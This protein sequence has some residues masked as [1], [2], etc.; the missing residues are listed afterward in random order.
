MPAHEVHG[1]QENKNEGNDLPRR[2][3]DGNGMGRNNVGEA[4]TTARAKEARERREDAGG[5][6]CSVPQ[7]REGRGIWIR[8]RR[9]A[10]A[11]FRGREEDG[12]SKIGGERVEPTV[13]ADKADI[14]RKKREGGKGHITSGSGAERAVSCK[15]ACWGLQTRGEGSRESPTVADIVS[16]PQGKWE[17]E[18]R[19][20]Q[21]LA[22]EYLSRL[23]TLSFN[24]EVDKRSNVDGRR[25]IRPNVSTP[26][27]AISSPKIQES[28]FV[29]KTSV[30][31]LNSS[32]INN[33]GR[34]FEIGVVS[35]LCLRLHTLPVKSFYL[36]PGSE[37]SSPEY[38]NTI[39]RRIKQRESSKNNH[40]S[41]LGCVAVLNRRAVW[42][43]RHHNIT[44]LPSSHSESANLPHVS[45]FQAP[46][47]ASKNADD[48]PKRLVRLRSY[49]SAPSSSCQATD[50]VAACRD[51]IDI[52]TGRTCS[53]SIL[54]QLLLVP[55]FRRASPT[56]QPCLMNSLSLSVGDSGGGNGD[57]GGWNSAPKGELGAAQNDAMVCRVALVVSRLFRVVPNSDS[58]A[59]GMLSD[60]AGPMSEGGASP[61][62]IST[63]TSA[64]HDLPLPS[65]RHLRSF[66]PSCGIHISCGRVDL[67][68]IP[69]APPLLFSLSR[70]SSSTFCLSLT[71]SLTQTHIRGSTTRTQPRLVSTTLQPPLPRPAIHRRL[72]AERA[73]LRR[74]FRYG[75]AIP[76]LE[77]RRGRG[78][79]MCAPRV[80]WSDCDASDPERGGR[81]TGSVF[82]GRFERGETCEG[83]VL[84]ARSVRDDGGRR[85]LQRCLRRVGASRPVSSVVRLPLIS[86]VADILTRVLLA[87]AVRALDVADSGPACRGVECCSLA[88]PSIDLVAYTGDSLS[89][90]LASDV[91][92]PCWISSY[93]YTDTTEGFGRWRESDIGVAGIAHWKYSDVMTPR[94]SGEVELSASLPPNPRAAYVDRIPRLPCCTRPRPPP[95]ALNLCP[96]CV[97]DAVPLAGISSRRLDVKISLYT[98][99][100]CHSLLCTAYASFSRISAAGH[101]FGVSHLV[102]AAAMTRQSSSN[103]GAQRGGVRVR[104]RHQENP[105]MPIRLNSHQKYIIVDNWR[106][107]RDC[108]KLADWLCP[109]RLMPIITNYRGLWQWKGEI[110]YIDHYYNR[111][112]HGYK[113]IATLKQ[114]KWSGQTTA[115]SI[116]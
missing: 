75:R 73:E 37:E 86:K 81:R 58:S 104:V 80:S 89:W 43:A 67:H 92:M 62:P 78:R 72:G 24:A 32:G 94:R 1:I 71:E 47:P 97:R 30:P 106:Q 13:Q 70:G 51:V 8:R 3:R 114:H 17:G 105:E 112:E 101:G 14:S 6:R 55:L 19:A 63:N 45:S 39:A 25:P 83:R 95:P 65:S 35:I 46:H 69:L 28:R 40:Q 108:P 9:R 7:D 98:T 16:E 53:Q 57:G 74:S 103:I 42:V 50:I 36:L 84:D 79:G 77:M 87:P 66:H 22:V 88:H 85:G 76:V 23:N 10:T 48:S 52:D 113:A 4:K 21:K 18:G 34:A 59:S 44:F 49:I 5:S 115:S 102:G 96:T 109:F 12:I 27:T 11:M 41:S 100:Y 29:I 90:S 93:H 111:G 26:N 2:N 31:G 91:R 56:V 54:F 38:S 116:L 61:Y 60:P 110:I 20:R 33:R 68:V 107:L 64:F 99:R 15:E 82:C